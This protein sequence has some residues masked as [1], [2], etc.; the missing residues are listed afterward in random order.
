M[1]ADGMG[2][3]CST[4]WRYEKCMKYSGW[5]IWREETLGRPRRRWE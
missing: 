4:H 5:K 1:K 3:A 2:G